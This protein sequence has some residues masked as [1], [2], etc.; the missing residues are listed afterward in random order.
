MKDWGSLWFVDHGFIRTIWSNRY[1]LPGGLYRANQPSPGM[2]RW[3]RRRLGIRSVINLRGENEE[4]GFYRLEKYACDREGVRLVNAKTWSRGLL[5]VQELEH[6]K[7]VIETVETPA[8]AHCK[9]GA[10]RAGFFAVLWRHWRLG[11]PLETALSELHW[12]FGHFKS[13]KTGMLDHFFETYLREREPEQTLID[14]IRSGYKPDEIKA[15]FSPKPWASWFVDDV[16]R[17][18]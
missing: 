13:A 6:L 4:Y 12:R 11:E 14:W 3:C 15:S 18:E 5:T 8:L 16:L 10:D 1:L 17:R 9:S 2:I 7:L